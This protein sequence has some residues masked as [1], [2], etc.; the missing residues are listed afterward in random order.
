MYAYYAPLEES[1]FIREV[2]TYFPSGDPSLPT[3]SCRT[4]LEYLDR[5]AD[6]P[7]MYTLIARTL[8][9]HKRSWSDV[10]ERFAV[11]QVKISQLR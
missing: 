10:C 8:D 11:L 3:T 7:G 2:L 4:I 6:L 1:E 9:H 5:H